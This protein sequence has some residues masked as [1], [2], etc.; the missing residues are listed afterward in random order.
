MLVHDSSDI[1]TDLL[2]MANYA[3][4]DAA[5]G[6]YL[7]ESLFILNIITWALTRLYYYAFEVVGNAHLHWPKLLPTRPAD[8]STTYEYLAQQASLV[9][10]L[11]LLY[12]LVVL[13]VL[14]WCLFWRILYRLL[15]KEKAHE[16][17][18]DEYEGTSESEDD[19]IEVG[20]ITWSLTY[21][22]CT[23][24]A[25]IARGIH[26]QAAS[27]RCSLP[28]RQPTWVRQPCSVPCVVSSRGVLHSCIACRRQ[29]GNRG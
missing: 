22:E 2:K 8:G 28:L 17:G 10:C 27:C 24:H 7:S 21:V 5:A 20:A 14:W 18:A 4:L 25:Y 15:K 13:N 19:E 1:I 23:C 12:F 29:C 16:I 26:R 9:A 6:W 3:G 11:T